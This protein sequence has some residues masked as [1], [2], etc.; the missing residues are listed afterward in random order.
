MNQEAPRSADFPDKLLH[1]LLGEQGYAL[2]WP[3]SLVPVERLEQARMGVAPGQSPNRL[4]QAWLAALIIA[5][6]AAERWL[7]ERRRSTDG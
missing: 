4:L 6:W 7:S 2:S 3:E 5:L 1:A